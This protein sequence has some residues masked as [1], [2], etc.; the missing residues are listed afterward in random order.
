MIVAQ[1]SLAILL[2]LNVVGAF[3]TAWI[4]RGTLPRSWYLQPGRQDLAKF[5]ERLPLILANIT[6]LG[7]LSFVTLAVLGGG[8]GLE[9]PPALLLLASAM[10]V[11]ACD[12]VGFYLWHRLMHRLPTLY[13]VVH[14]IHHR[15]YAP[16]P[17]DYLYVH[18]LEWMVGILAPTLGF[19]ILWLA[20]GHLSAWVIWCYAAMRQIHELNLHSGLRSVINVRV[21]FLGT[22]DHHDLHHARPNSGNYGA[23]SSLWDR[24]MGTMARPGG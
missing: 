12:D 13:R 20:Q 5:K 21:P 10:F 18:P 11:W 17:L 23:A 24:L 1:V 19:G 4:G 14:R 3:A 6:I 15:A 9:R 8:L 7:T 2:G 22:T 16:L